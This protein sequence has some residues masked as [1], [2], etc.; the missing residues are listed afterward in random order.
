MNTPQAATAIDHAISVN[1]I[2]TFF[3]VRFTVLID[4]GSSTPAIDTLNFRISIKT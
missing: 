4:A 1:Q 2:G 3:A